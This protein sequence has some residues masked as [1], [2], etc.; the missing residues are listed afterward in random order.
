MSGREVQKSRRESHRLGGEHV[1]NCCFFSELPGQES[2]SGLLQPLHGHVVIPGQPSNDFGSA[3]F[4][5][6]YHQD[7]SKADP[8][9]PSKRSFR[10]FEVGQGPDHKLEVQA[11]EYHVVHVSFKP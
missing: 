9:W 11:R 8:T 7:W 2:L 6:V 3:T 5:I 10:L 1:H 4:Y